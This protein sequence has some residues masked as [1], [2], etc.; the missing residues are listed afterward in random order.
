MQAQT[1]YFHKGGYIST[2]KQVYQKEGVIG[3]YRGWIP[4]VIGS[5]VYRSS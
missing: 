3:F 4:P 5:I 1:E 2:V